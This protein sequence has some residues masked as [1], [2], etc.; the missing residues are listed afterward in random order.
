M[1]VAS[2][3]AEDTEGF[4]KDGLQVPQET[5]SLPRL[6]RFGGGLAAVSSKNKLQ[7][8]QISMRPSI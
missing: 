2:K 1:K 6:P 4:A 3:D 7:K 5:R 8:N